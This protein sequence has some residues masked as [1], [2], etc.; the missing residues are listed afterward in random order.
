MSNSPGFK[1]ASFKKITDSLI[2][3]PLM[4]FI[5]RAH[6]FLQSNEKKNQNYATG[7]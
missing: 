4:D 6:F 2:N 7:W 5:Q 1:Q 3:N